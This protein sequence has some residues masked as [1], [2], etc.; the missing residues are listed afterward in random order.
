MFADSLLESAVHRPTR[1][2]SLSLLTSLALEALVVAVLVAIPLVH[3]DM[4]AAAPPRII[5]Q[6]PIEDYAAQPGPV[7]HSGGGG[8]SPHGQPSIMP[9]FHPTGH[10]LFLGP[11]RSTNVDDNR[12]FCATCPIGPDIGPS[13]GP[14]F[15]NARPLPPPPHHP[16][17]V[18]SHFDPGTLVHQVLPIYPEIAKRA[19]IQG[20]VRLQAVITPEGTIAQLTVISGH[21]LLAPAALDAVRQWRFRPYLL[22]GQAVPVE[23]TITVNFRLGADGG[24]L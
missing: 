13:I 6:V 12:P 18:I 19:R 4:L 11:A 22:N 16:P 23:T 5:Y 15:N 17:V 3:P 20:D 7:H 9:T 10:T 2:R 24:A 21:P 14:L 1:R 8:G